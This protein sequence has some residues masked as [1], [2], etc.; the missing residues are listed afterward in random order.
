[1]LA[2]T[3]LAAVRDAA[4]AQG[5]ELPLDPP[6]AQA[7]LGGVLATAAVGPRHLGWGRPRDFVLGLTVVL[8][9]G[10]L[11]RSGGRVVKNVTGY[12]VMKLHLGSLGAFGVIASAWLRLRPRPEAERCVA[13]ALPEAQVSWTRAIDVARHATARA[14][15]LCD[16]RLA[17]AVAPA[18]APPNGWLAIV[19]CAGDAAAVARDIAALVAQGGA[20]CTDGAAV[21]RARSLQG[22]TFGASGLRFRVSSLPSRLAGVADVL[23]DAGAAL[24]VH[25]GSGLVHARVALDAEGDGAGLDRAWRAARAAATAGGGSVVLEAAPLWARAARDVFGEP[26]D[27]WRLA[28]LAKERFDPHCVLNPGRFAGGL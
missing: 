4:T 25:P 13:L 3:P 8:G 16:A 18:L 27:A 26:S 10:L 1:V 9:D 2:G 6:G 24:L 22:E 14:C 12:D 7:T 15:V 28:R 5:W 20:E 17:P 19:E 11:T 23:R 21:A